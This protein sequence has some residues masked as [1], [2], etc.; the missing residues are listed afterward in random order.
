MQLDRGQF[1]SVDQKII[2]TSIR[3]KT[4]PL[5][6]GVLIGSFVALRRFIHQSK[7]ALIAKRKAYTTQL[8]ATISQAA[9]HLNRIKQK[10]WRNKVDEAKKPESELVVN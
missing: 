3:A 5:L 8:R 10:D 1:L 2:R 7:F 6:W 4:V 9:A